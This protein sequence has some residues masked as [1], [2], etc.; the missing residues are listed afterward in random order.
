MQYIKIEKKEYPIHFGYAA[1]ARFEL[2]FNKK[3]TQ[4]DFNAI[5]ILESIQ[6]I[7]CGFYDGHRHAKKRGELSKKDKFNLSVED[8]ADLIDTDPQLMPKLLEQFSQSL[9][10]ADQEKEEEKTEEGNGQPPK[11]A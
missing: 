4:L 8:I 11:T 5:G 6:I 7:W 10:P 2:Q 1:L 9:A 3:I